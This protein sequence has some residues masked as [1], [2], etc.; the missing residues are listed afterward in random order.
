MELRGNKKRKKA[1][2]KAKVINLKGKFKSL[3]SGVEGNIE[4][5]FN[6]KGYYREFID[7][8]I[9]GWVKSAINPNK[10][11]TDYSFT[12][13]ADYKGKYLEQAQKTHIEAMSDWRK[14]FKEIK[15]VGIEEIEVKNKSKNETINETVKVYVLRLIND[16]IPEV[17]LYID[18]KTGDILKQKMQLLNPI[19]GSIPVIF[20][21]SDYRDYKGLRLPYAINIR[22]DVTGETEI[23]FDSIKTKLTLNQQDFII[24]DPKSGE[25]K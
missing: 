21:Y 22:N 17:K 25:Q 14:V 1:L 11:S 9:Y 10:A 7:M 13:Y 18:V 20:N 12:D 23:K 24:K 19:F 2:K 6:G 8:G 16:N 4:V 3:Q 15:V 5:Y